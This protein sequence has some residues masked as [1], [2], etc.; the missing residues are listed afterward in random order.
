M[1]E[2]G[3]D[4]DD[5]DENYNNYIY[6]NDNNDRVVL[7]LDLDCFYAQAMCIRYGLDVAITPLALFQWNSVLAVTYPARTFY[8]IKRG[9]TWDDVKTKSQGKCLCVHV[10]ILT[11][12][13]ANARSSSFSS[14]HCNASDDNTSSLLLGETT[15]VRS[16]EDP[17][18]V[19]SSM[20][21]ISGAQG[22]PGSTIEEEYREYFQL[23]PQ[24]QK[25]AQLRE[26]GVRKLS[27]D[28]KASI[29]CFRI[30]ST[31]IFGVVKTLLQEICVSRN[32]DN[33]KKKH[34]TA[35]IILERASID[36]FFLDVTAA[37]D[38]WRCCSDNNNH[39]ND[40][41]PPPSTIVVGQNNDNNALDSKYNVSQQSDDLRI[42]RGCIIAERIRVKVW[43]ELKFTLTAGIS[44]NK[45]IAKLAAAYGKPNGQAVCYP[46]YISIML[47]TTPISKCRNLGGKLGSAVE[48]LIRETK[49]SQIAATTT[50]TT[51]TTGATTT[52]EKNAMVGDIVQYLSLP[53]LLQKG[54]FS[55]TTARWIWNIGH[56]CDDEPV[57]SKDQTA[58][59]TKSITAFKSLNFFGG[60][61]DDDDH[62]KK[63]GL[64]LHEIS[65]WIALLAQEV[66]HRVTRDEQ[67]NHRYPKN[68]VIQ[69]TTSSYV[70]KSIR[71][72]FPSSRWSN[73]QKQDHLTAI[74]P[75]TVANKEQNRNVRLRRI[76]LC[77]TEFEQRR[78]AGSSSIGR[79]FTEE[80][81][82]A[83]AVATVKSTTPFV[84]S[85]REIANSAT[86]T[87]SSTMDNESSSSSSLSSA[88]RD[89][90]L[91]KSL[92]AKFDREERALLV[93]EARKRKKSTGCIDSFFPKKRGGKK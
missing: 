81:V 35:T 60:G 17:S 78:P 16:D 61:D 73:S 14:I 22:N 84:V 89:L 45:T 46:R 27:T 4:D 66:I 21:N 43:D 6:N 91:A 51:T 75:K 7:L 55:E 38:Q 30:A 62:Q 5:H 92:Q 57:H 86:I 12:A 69:Y 2:S 53:L 56:G 28:G 87:T 58:V 90:A 64:L 71:I 1:E 31:R 49:P 44:I 76:G 29:E 85:K 20:E 24:M 77:A 33:D 8:G 9:D 70:S 11:T 48:K 25:E 88:D 18:I 34:E 41:E 74:V 65:H 10:P 80:A 40:C 15:M 36:E 37:V 79:F 19:K 42:A 47:Q 39:N 63:N 23:S 13:K 54:G 83:T 3:D 72:P 82:C 68:C 52:S 67:R 59:L 32:D 26:L 50:T 93:L